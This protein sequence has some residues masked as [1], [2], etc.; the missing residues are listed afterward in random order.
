MAAGAAAPTTSSSGRSGRRRDKRARRSASTR[1]PRSVRA[2]RADA[3]VRARRRR[4]RARARRRVAVGARVACI[5]AVLGR[6]DAAAG[7]RA[8]AARDRLRS[9]RSDG[10]ARRDPAGRGT[11]WRMG[12]ALFAVDFPRPSSDDM[13]P[14]IRKG[15]LLLACRVCGKPQRGDV[16]LFTSPDNGPLSIRRVVARARRSRRG[17]QRRDPGQRQAARRER[18]RHRQARR[19]R[20]GVEPAAAVL[21]GRREDRR[22]RVQGGARPRRRSRP[23]TARR[24]RSTTPTSWPPIGA[25]SCATAATT[26]R[27]A[28]AIDPLDRRARPVGRRSRRRPP[29]PPAR[30]YSRRTWPSSSTGRS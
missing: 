29:G 2:L 9:P 21:A 14:G 15:D 24:R 27:C 10:R 17:A 18:R 23:A 3:G 11:A 13:A 7:A 16:V 12:L 28:R 19:H 8:L 6:S 25:R 1:S 22:A 30:S 26:V 20:P 4:R 5:G